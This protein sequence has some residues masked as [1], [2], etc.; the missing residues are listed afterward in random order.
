MEHFSVG[1]VGTGHGGLA[2]GACLAYVG[3]GVTCLDNNQ[4]RVAGLREGRVPVYEP[5]LEELIARGAQ[6]GSTLTAPRS[7]PRSYEKPTSSS[8]PSVPRSTV[9]AR[10]TSRT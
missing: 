9:T 4:G 6:E 3:H 7:W 5:G 8:W 2:T 1:A 10:P